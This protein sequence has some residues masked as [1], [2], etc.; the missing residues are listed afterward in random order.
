MFISK[1]CIWK[2]GKRVC[3]SPMRSRT[4]SDSTELLHSHSKSKNANHWQKMASKMLVFIQ[5]LLNSSNLFLRQDSVFQSRSVRFWRHFSV[6]LR[7]HLHWFA[8]SILLFRIMF[9]PISGRQRISMVNPYTL[10]YRHNLTLTYGCFEITA[11]LQLNWFFL[12]SVQKFDPA[13]QNAVISERNTLKIRFFCKLS[14]FFFTVP[15]FG[16]DATLGRAKLRSSVRARYS[17]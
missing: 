2:S 16:S 5:K 14:G 6:G 8:S 4:N 3:I 11:K 17:W 10:F 13:S 15:T 9:L 12:F 1:L 7:T